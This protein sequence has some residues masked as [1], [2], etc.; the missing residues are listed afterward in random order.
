MGVEDRYKKRREEEEKKQKATTQ[1]SSEKKETRSLYNGV[2]NRFKAKNIK[3]NRKN[4]GA[5]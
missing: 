2:E 5:K 4:T 1:N 3:T